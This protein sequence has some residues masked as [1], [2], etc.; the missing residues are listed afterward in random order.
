[1]LSIASRTSS[2]NPPATQQKMHKINYGTS[3][4]YKVRAI[5]NLT[6]TIRRDSHEA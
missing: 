6:R 1:L 3:A 4:I 2:L 5:S